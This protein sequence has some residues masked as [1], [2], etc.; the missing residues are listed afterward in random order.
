M[1]L[2]TATLLR[3]IATL[4]NHAQCRPTDGDGLTRLRK[5]RAAAEQAWVQ[6]GS[7]DLP[8]G[9]DKP[10]AMPAGIGTGAPTDKDWTRE[11]IEVEVKRRTDRGILIDA[12]D[13][14]FWC[15]LSVCEGAD[16][17][18][19]GDVGTVRVPRWVLP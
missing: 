16:D 8:G 2:E 15:P 6:A 5:A 17:L 14:G 19:D 10:T 9:T 7:P 13:G 12:G 4:V 3:A 1:T 18:G 11:A